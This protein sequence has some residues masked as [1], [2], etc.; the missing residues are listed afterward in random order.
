MDREHVALADPAPPSAPQVE[1]GRAARRK[2]MI[3][4]GRVLP[5]L[6]VLIVPNVAVILSQAA[7]NF[8]E[9]YY[10]GLIGLD[11]LAGAALVFP[12]VMLMQTM[13]AGGVGGAMAAA[14]A[15]A[16]GSGQR[17][18]A[19]ALLLHAVVI[20][21]AA[22]I[23]FSAAALLLGPPIYRAMGG[24]GGGLAAALTYSNV[25]FGGAIFLWLM[26]ALASVLRGAGNMVLPAVVLVTG[27]VVLLGMSPLLIFG[28]G[29]V[30]Q[31]GIAGAGLALVL[32]YAIG[33]GILFAT[34]LRGKGGL[35]FSLRHR[36]RR[37]LFGEIVGVGALGAANNVLTNLAVIL[38][39]G[40]VGTFGVEAIVGFGLGIRVEYLQ[41]PLV[42]GI[43]SGVVPMVGM[44]IGAGQFAR[45]KQV[46][47]TGACIA[48]GVTETIGLLVAAFPHAWLGLFTDDAQAIAAGTA[49]LR[50]VGPFYG[51]LGLSLALY[52]A[53]QG[54]GRM[55][56]PTLASLLRVI[57]IACGGAL[58]VRFSGFGMLL[59]VVLLAH[60]LSAGTN[61][62][63]WIGAPERFARRIG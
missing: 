57:V 14:V 42:F 38:A 7:A 35:R 22:G 26:N 47:W 44:N 46:A 3:L 36:L 37:A 28:W 49:Y 43:G 48:V 50:Q 32:Y 16:I 53:S 23:A 40:L 13:S 4:H 63:N 30:P 33:S 51:L 27:T 19:E 45:A 2:A 60:A 59:V 55:R 11:G 62:L 10:V 1:L 15:R 25:I 39:T 58:A 18:K 6:L 5:T 56:L 9:S 34:M 52:F 21:I 31:L 24:Q 17:E 8:L 29:P 61:C 12:L 54:A 20:A 41:I